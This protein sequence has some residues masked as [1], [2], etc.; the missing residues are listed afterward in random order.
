MDI[1]NEAQADVAVPSL[2]Q[3]EELTRQNLTLLRA[4]AMKMREALSAA[5][6]DN[7]PYNRHDLGANHH[8][9]NDKIHNSNRGRRWEQRLTPKGH[10][11]YYSLEAK[12]S[13]IDELIKS[14]DER[15]PNLPKVEKP[16]NKRKPIVPP[17]ATEF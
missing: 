1:I 3:G 16:L 7:Y 14:I 9:R 4:R 17:E 5:M 8:R 12:R 2:P 15:L 6:K 11:Y 10:E 13:D